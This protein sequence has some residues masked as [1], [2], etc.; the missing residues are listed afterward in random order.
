MSS[1]NGSGPTSSCH[2]DDEWDVKMAEGKTSLIAREIYLRKHL[3]RHDEAI[4]IRHS[5]TCVILM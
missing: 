1:G 2:G 3:L 5:V 4:N